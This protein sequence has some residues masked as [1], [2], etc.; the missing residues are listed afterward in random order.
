MVEKKL[1]VCDVCEE[2]VSKM[3]CTICG[4]DLCSTCAKRLPLVS[5]PQDVEVIRVCKK[6]LIKTS[7]LFKNPDFVDQYRHTFAKLIQSASI[8]EELEEDD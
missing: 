2:K 4:K 5:T 3:N 1:Q 8:L 6:C 7:S